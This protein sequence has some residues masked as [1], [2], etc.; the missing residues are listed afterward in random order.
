VWGAAAALL[1]L[2]LIAMQFTAEVNW[3]PFDFL[4]FGTMLLAACGFYEM[5]TRVSARKP[6]RLAAGIA[7]VGAFLQVWANLAVGIVGNESNPVNLMFFAVP[8]LG[9]IGAILVRFDA[10]GLSRTLVLM[11][12]TQLLV[13]LLAWLLS[14]ANVLV[15]TAFFVGVWLIAARLF[16][17]ARSAS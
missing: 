10:R 8:L 3:T 7:V 16:Q 14:G 12:L 13:G 6:Y 9:M 1:L 11:A 4:V 15:F 5:A 2:P 17:Q